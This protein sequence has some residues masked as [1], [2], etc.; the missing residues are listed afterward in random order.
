MLIKCR[1]VAPSPRPY[2]YSARLPHTPAVNL[3]RPLTHHSHTFPSPPFI[4]D[5]YVNN[6]QYGITREE[7]DAYGLRSW[8]N[9]KKAF[10][11]GI[12]NDE[13]AGIEIKGKKGVELMM[14][15]EHPRELATLAD[16][17]RLKPV[18]KENG[19]VTAANASGICDGAA[20]LIVASE[21]AVKQHGLKPLARIVSW[22]RTGE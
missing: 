11:A 6:K 17:A 18:F 4:C 15:D 7:C 9:W 10:E 8:T 13:I 20:S 21:E 5:H 12:F 2:A 22:A 19:R 16:M 1:R 3:L 14:R